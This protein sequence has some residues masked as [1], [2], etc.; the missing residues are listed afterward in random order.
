M[1]RPRKKKQDI[2][3]R[4]AGTAD[5]LRDILQEQKHFNCPKDKDILLDRS[6]EYF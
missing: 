4:V 6:T 5:A 2:H 1:Q 3:S